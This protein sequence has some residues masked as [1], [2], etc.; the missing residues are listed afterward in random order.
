MRRVIAAL[1]LI[2]A[3]AVT[4][5]AAEPGAGIAAYE[6]G[7]YVAAMAAWRPLAEAGDAEAQ[8]YLGVLHQ[9]GLGVAKDDLEASRWYR[10]AAEQDHRE[11]AKRLALINFAGDHMW[12]SKQQAVQWFRRAAELGDAES[13]GFLGVMYREGWGVAA[14]PV[15]ALVWLTLAVQQGHAKAAEDRRAL[16]RT[17]TAA[18]LVEAEARARA[19]RPRGG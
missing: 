16:V 9:H 5:A 3:A 4:P 10:R 8:F 17:M 2:L 19:W 12:T 6:R 7:D 1:S 15:E 11:A 13:Q 14:D 18:E